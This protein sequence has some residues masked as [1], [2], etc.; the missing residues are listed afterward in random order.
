M[1]DPHEKS[2]LDSLR[3]LHVTEGDRSQSST[4][5]PAAHE[6]MV[7]RVV[8]SGEADEQATPTLAHQSIADLATPV[9]RNATSHAVSSPSAAEDGVPQ[10]Q[11]Q[12]KAGSTLL[13]R[14]LE[15][16]GR[17]FTPGED[18]DGSEE[19]DTSDATLSRANVAVGRDSSHLDRFSVSTPLNDFSSDGW[20]MVDGRVRRKSTTSGFGGQFPAS[21]PHSGSVRPTESLT[22]GVDEMSVV[23]SLDEASSVVN[24]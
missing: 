12:N 15:I 4:T 9:I 11:A 14:W 8:A 10:S 24:E 16:N 20:S 3:C 7:G 18:S 6:A 23:T 22:S 17:A 2:L 1:E 19:S 21:T 5:S 13:H